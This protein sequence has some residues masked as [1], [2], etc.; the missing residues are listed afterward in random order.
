MGCSKSSPK[1]EVYSNTILSQETIK[2]SHRQPNFIPKTTKK[3]RT[4]KN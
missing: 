3:R 2:T 1:R 4:K